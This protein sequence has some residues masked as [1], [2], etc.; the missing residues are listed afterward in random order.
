MRRP[1]PSRR[2]TAAPALLA[3][4]LGLWLA[5]AAAAWGHDFWIEAQ[6]FRVAP[7]G[8]A[9]LVLREGVD[10]TGNRLP[11]IP[12]WF[13]RYTVTGPG[14][15]R[16][17]EGILG[18]DPA[19][20][21]T[22]AE[23]GAHVVAYRSSG[24]RVT[25]PPERFRTY[26]AEEG[27]EHIRELRAEYGE[28]DDSADERFFRCAKAIVHAGPPAADGGGPATRPVGL[29]LELVPEADPASLAP[30]QALGLRL[31]F[32]EEPVSGVLV[33]GFTRAAPQDRVRA[34]T[35][36]GGRAALPLPRAG[37]WL[38]KAVH[39]VRAPAGS[40]VEWISYWASLTFALPEG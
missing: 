3:L 28:T 12:A 27:L 14:G 35:D 36:A 1:T 16:P 24:D 15:Q 10:F 19:G 2:L 11:Y 40:E 7:G 31:R 8:E 5:G 37:T 9:A 25:L 6:P 22:L 21:L 32:R 33:V 39:M 29:E 4:A 20:R 23:P 17:V 38:V 26:L 34:R 13:E 18:D 30:G